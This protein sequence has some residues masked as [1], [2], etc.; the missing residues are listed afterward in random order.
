[1][2]RATRR[3]SPAASN[4]SKHYEDHLRRSASRSPIRPR[5]VPLTPRSVSPGGGGAYGRPLSRSAT[6][7]PASPPGRAVTAT[8]PPSLL[9]PL[10][11]GT[12]PESLPRGAN[13]RSAPHKRQPF[14][15]LMKL[16]P[17]LGV[18]PTAFRA[19]TWDPDVEARMWEVRASE[20]ASAMPGTKTK[21]IPC[22]ATMIRWRPKRPPSSADGAAPRPLPTADTLVSVPDVAAE[23]NANIVTWSDGSLTLM[24]GDQT[25][26]MNDQ[27]EA[28]GQSRVFVDEPAGGND[29]EEL[30]GGDSDEAGERGAGV[31]AG[32]R[33]CVAAGVVSVLSRVVP[34]M[35]H[36]KKAVGSIKVTAGMGGGAGAGAAADRDSR[37]RS[38]IRAM[39]GADGGGGGGGGS[40]GRRVLLGTSELAPE[41][42]ERR[43]VAAEQ[44]REREAARAESRRRQLHMR[45]LVKAGGASRNA[46]GYGGGGGG[47]GPRGA[48]LSSG[49]LQDDDEEEEVDDDEMDGRRYGDDDEEDLLVQS[50]SD[51]GDYR[52]KRR[53][54]SAAPEDA[55]RLAHL[56]RGGG[57]EE[58]G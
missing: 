21:V 4:G 2:S 54:G 12:E 22:P 7:P 37:R 14:L 1:M 13:P 31:S 56:Q 40:S 5:S 41:V 8:A 29:D 6:P 27:F 55:E 16:P 47:G 45:A 58:A 18:E 19:G 11:A 25:F 26:M 46:G 35:T 53:R 44:Q 42:E 24:V 3:E 15:S 33:L 34:S 10:P 32:G 51:S 48:G 39:G 43:R 28:P 50:G 30:N 57:G 38:N 17:A 52:R 23:S 36:M 49:F 9:P 20:V